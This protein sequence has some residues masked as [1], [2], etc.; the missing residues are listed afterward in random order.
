MEFAFESWLCLK[1]FKR[2]N[3]ELGLLEFVLGC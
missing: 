3:F 2:W 1:D